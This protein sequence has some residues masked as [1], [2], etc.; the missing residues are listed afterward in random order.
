MSVEKIDVH[1]VAKLARIE[2]TEDETEAFGKQ[3]HDIVAYV[4]QLDT[5]DISLIPESHL[6]DHT[7][8]NHLRADIA[9][10]GLPC[11]KVLQNAPAAVDGE[12]VMPKIVE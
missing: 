4:Q 9:C 11:E 8:G 10:P 6:D 7:S 12:I 1:Y 5:A 2:L 3:L